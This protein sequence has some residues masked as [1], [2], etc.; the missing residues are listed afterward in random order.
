MVRLNSKRNENN[1][2]KKHQD[3]VFVWVIFGST[4]FRLKVD[5]KLIHSIKNSDFVSNGTF[6]GLIFYKVLKVRP[7]RLVP[8]T[9]V[10][11]EYILNK[12]WCH[13][14]KWHSKEWPWVTSCVVFKSKIWLISDSDIFKITSRLQFFSVKRTSYFGRV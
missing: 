12:I 3:R 10:W 8:W 7:G 11:N 6:Y 2:D 9:S 1:H 13:Q 14:P 5:Q 4:F